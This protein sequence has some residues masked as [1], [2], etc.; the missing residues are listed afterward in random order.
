MGKPRLRVSPPGFFMRN[1][2]HRITPQRHDRKQYRHLPYI[3]ARAQVVPIVVEFERFVSFAS[4][5]Y[6]AVAESA[7]DSETLQQDRTSSS[8]ASPVKR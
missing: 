7:T 2:V 8:R 1:P 6:A 4:W 5:R 3:C